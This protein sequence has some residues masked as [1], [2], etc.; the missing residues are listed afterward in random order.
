MADQR[1]APSSGDLIVEAA[2]LLA[3]GDDEAALN[4][5]Q[6]AAA[7]EAQSARFQFLTGLL[8]WRFSN[9]EQALAVLRRCHELDPMNGSVAEVLASLVAQAGDLVESLYL[10]KIATARGPKEGYAELIPPSFPSFGQAFLAIQERPLFAR[11]KLMAQSG[12]LPGAIDFAGQH[13]SLNPGDDEARRF[14]ADNLLR[15]GAAG[16]ALVVLRPA[17]ERTPAAPDFLSRYAQALTLV[18]KH[19]E[20]RKHHDA[21]CKA[22]APADAS[23]AAARV[24]GSLWLDSGVDAELTRAKDWASRFLPARKTVSL[25]RAE[26]KLVIGYLVSSLADPLD[27]A[28]VAAVAK[29]HDRSRFSVIAFGLGQQSWAENAMLS[30]AFDKWRD[31]SD[32]DPATLARVLRGDGLAVVIDCAGFANPRQLLA[33]GRV[34]TALRVGWLGMPP[35]LGAPFYDAVLGR[36]AGETP[37][38][39]PDRNY[40]LVRDWIKPITHNPSDAIRF[41]SDIGLSQLDA[42]TVRLWSSVLAGA[43]GASL[44]LR[45]RDMTCGSNIDHLIGCFGRDVAARVDIVEAAS[46]EDFYCDVDISLAPC[47]GSSPRMVAES[48]ACAV[49]AVAL[50]GATTYEP[51]GAFLRGLGLGDRLVAA[52]EQDYISIALGLAGSA[53]A[54]AP[55]TAAVASIAKAGEASARCVAEIVE[56]NVLKMLT[57]VV[58]S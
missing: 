27:A 7:S 17:A 13:V 19:E 53:D 55:L 34:N 29:A 33:L 24:A 21:A 1:S 20:A 12:Q 5:L 31:I 22:A 26:G 14:L 18:G 32:V 4:T 54:R 37:A 3:A 42:A 40:P 16:A 38:W 56:T 35:G 9:L 39:G 43:P 10:G 50:A 8:A 11:A 44:A 45:A 52:D 48:I 28:A 15:I 2:R 25:P 23:V 57:E 46:P 36:S 49:P 51:Y 30:G 41:G 47:R 6:A 58:G